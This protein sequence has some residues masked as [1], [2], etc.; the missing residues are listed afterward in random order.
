MQRPGYTFLEIVTVLTVAAVLFG[1]SLGYTNRNIVNTN[2]NATVN[3]VRDAL[4]SAQVNS[5]SNYLDLT[6]GVHFEADKFVEFTATTYSASDTNNRETNLPSTLTINP[7]TING[8]GSEI[9]FSKF[10]GRPVNSGSVTV[11]SDIDSATISVS[12]EG[13]I[14][15]TFN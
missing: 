13:V 1:I 2:F 7:I 10:D 6:S 11:A 3:E 12:A 8:G 4:Q 15:V 9:Y 5:R 14:S